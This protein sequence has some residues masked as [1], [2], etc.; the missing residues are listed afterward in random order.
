MLFWTRFCAQVILNCV[1]VTL[2]FL[3]ITDRT[4]LVQYLALCPS[5]DTL[6]RR[7]LLTLL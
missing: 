7:K 3:V 5:S 4:I 6:V 1:Q 2:H